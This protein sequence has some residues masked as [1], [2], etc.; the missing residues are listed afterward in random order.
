M[1]CNKI[2][3]GIAQSRFLHLWDKDAQFVLTKLWKTIHLQIEVEFVGVFFV[4]FFVVANPFTNTAAFVC[5]F[6]SRGSSR[7][8]LTHGLCDEQG[9][10]VRRRGSHGIE[11]SWRAASRGSLRLVWGQPPQKDDLI[12]YWFISI[13]SNWHNVSWEMAKQCDVSSP[14]TTGTVKMFSYSMFPIVLNVSMYKKLSS[15]ISFS[16]A[17]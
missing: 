1:R 10:R 2:K 16:G 7:W 9:G 17:E 15:C 11:S 6:P 14:H 3:P 8:V 5:Q 12:R 4:L 13:S